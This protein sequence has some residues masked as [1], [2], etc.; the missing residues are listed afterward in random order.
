MIKA[1]ISNCNNIVSAN[2]KLL[3]DH[4]NIRY[5]MNGTG[6]S[7]IAKAIISVLGVEDISRLQAFDSEN[8][9]ECHLSE[10]V[11]KVLLFNED[12]V[13]QFVFQR[14]E[15]IPD[16]FDVFIKTP[17]YEE[18]LK[19]INNKLKNIHVDLNENA[20]LQKIVST[21]K[22]VLLKFN[23]TTTGGLKKQGFMKSLISPE[24]IFKLPQKLVKFKPLMEKEYIAEWAGWKN[25]GSKYD[26]NGICPFCTTSL[27]AEYASEKK[28][29]SSSYTRSNINNIREMIS[30]FNTVKDYMESSKRDKLYE[31]IK[32]LKGEQEIQHWIE[33]FYSDLKLLVKKITSVVEFNT[34]Q[35]RSEDISGLEDQL[36][37]LIID[38]SDL[39]IFNNQKVKDS[40]KF[41]NDKINAV[42]SETD[43]LKREIGQLN[44]LINSAK[45][46]AI[47]DINDFLSTADIHY[48]FEIID[49]SENT[50]R[51]ILRYLSKTKGAIDVDDIS[52]HLSWGEKNAFA[53]VLFMHWALSQNP[54]II[55]LDDPI[56]SFDSN[57]KYAII[58][59][60]F[61]NV[62][63]KKSFYNKTI[64]MLTHD[65]QPIIDLVINNKPTGGFISAYFLQN[66][67]GVISELEITPADIQSLPIL[68]ADNCKND[69]LNKI[70][71]VASLRKLIEHMP[72][73][74]AAQKSAHNLLSCLLHGET[75]PVYINKEAMPIQE[76]KA[77]EEFV[78]GYI[79]DFEYDNYL[80][81]VFTKDNLLKSF[82][83]ENNSYFRI[84]VF[85]VLIEVLNLRSQIQDDTLLK[86][87][88]EQFHVEN[89]YIFTLDF[90]KYDIV[91]DFVVPKCLEYLKQKHLIS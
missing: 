69:K 37:K 13:N 65:L 1:D 20:D 85:R 64:L 17:E 63:N 28:I 30:Y 40:I 6:K 83:K 47:T 62:T 57:K 46:N 25:D 24:S 36:K 10:A 41:A 26:D 55:I 5:A 31:C 33:L 87:I 89:D 58:S 22:L 34:Y 61:A 79:A 42:L 39:Q 38:I 48:K 75:K 76:I 15:V 12:F 80:K 44:G 86:Y 84:Q 9:P 8:K 66:K 91:P 4:L 23:E 60:L 2:I 52:L 21:G 3:K 50:S 77:G 11:S 7:T 88:D 49:D 73:N 72:N 68:L 90:M 43:L 81:N 71:R 74:G 14:S 54:E 53:L 78:R 29:F 70:H 59:R 19:K 35:A 56:S 16:S 51:T 67:D 32:G 45:K 18:R 27:N 82:L